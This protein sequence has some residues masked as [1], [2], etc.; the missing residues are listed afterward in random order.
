MNHFCTITTFSHL[1]KT[2]AL[3]DS[4]KAIDQR[5]IVHILLIDADKKSVLIPDSITNCRL[6]TVEELISTTSQKIIKKYTGYNDKLR[7]SL[8]P[9]FIQHLLLNKI[10]SKI[11]YVDNDIVFFN[12]FAFL[13]DE[14]DKHPVLLTPHRYPTTPDK[15]QNWLEANFK[16]GLYNA[17]FIGANITAINTMEWWAKCCYYRCEKNAIRGLFDDQ[18]YL[19]LIPIIEPTAK[20]LNHKG[21]NVADWNIENCKRVFVNGKVLIDDIWPIIFM[22]FNKSTV[23]SFINGNDELLKSYFDQYILTLKKYKPTLKI[24][25]EGYTM[26]LMEKIKLNLWNFLNKLNNG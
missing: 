14:L 1:Y 23:Q 18:K 9:V 12:D 17:G 25:D 8:K 26:S 4:I 10:S 19:D 16:V 5:S 24:N 15:N 2:W 7:W 21:C 13:F 22:H 11:I 20:V 6:Y 3:L